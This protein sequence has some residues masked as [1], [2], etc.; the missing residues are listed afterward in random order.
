MKHVYFNPS[1]FLLSV[2]MAAC[3]FVHAQKQ[4][5][6]LADPIITLVDDG[7][8]VGG[9]GF[10]EGPLY[11]DSVGLVFSDIYNSK[12]FLY[13]PK[14]D[15]TTVYLNGSGNSN[16]LRLDL[17]GN[18]LL[19]QHGK[20]RIARIVNGVE[21]SVAEHYQGK[22]LNSPNDVT[23]KSDG[24]IFFT[25]PPYG[26]DANQAELDFSGIYRTS[27][28]GKTT[29]LDS[30]LERPNGI[31]FSLDEKYLYVDDTEKREIYRWDVTSDSTIAN[32][33][34]FAT[35][36]LSWDPNG[37]VDGI[38]LDSNGVLYVAGPGGVWV[39]DTNGTV[40][41]TIFMPA[42]TTNI[43]FDSNQTT[44]YVTTEKALYKI[45]RGTVVG[46]QNEQLASKTD[47]LGTNFPNPILQSTTIPVVLSKDGHAKLE[48]RDPQ[49]KS[50]STLVDGQLSAG[51]HQFTWQKPQNAVG[52]F[53][54]HL[55]VDSKSY[56]KPCLI[57]GN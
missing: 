39:L 42:W 12:V 18:L 43:A 13:S 54:I 51:E 48:I 1:R 28:S 40:L 7:T 47:P 31:V 16:G 21:D 45:Q 50:I 29:L 32:K 33:K 23:V 5:S 34:L 55:T 25:D 49:G 9:F 37:G 24:G 56:A 20:R 30:S 44:L 11:I 35:L 36:N 26:I 53:Y 4:T 38:V 57:R 6:I 8:S 17:Q 19:A 52:V 22:R 41:D 15:T 14:A 46:I 3:T 10:L 27:P 2:A